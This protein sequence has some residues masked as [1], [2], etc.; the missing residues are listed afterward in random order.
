MLDVHVL[1]ACPGCPSTN[2]SRT[3]AEAPTRATWPL[4]IVIRSRC[5]HT[6]R[7]AVASP[8]RAL[9]I[10]H[11]EQCWSEDAIRQPMR[12]LFRAR[13]EPLPS[14]R[15]ERVLPCSHET[16]QQRAQPC[17]QS[18]LS[19]ARFSVA[20][21]PCDWSPGRT[22]PPNLEVGWLERPIEQGRWCTSRS[23]NSRP[24]EVR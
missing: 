6:G 4:S 24:C 15:F 10:F 23:Y 21:T 17:V 14:F 18:H 7:I 16:R 19:K 9:E 5:W 8:Y 3:P 13:S 2:C 1:G 12:W 11:I 20:A 22:M